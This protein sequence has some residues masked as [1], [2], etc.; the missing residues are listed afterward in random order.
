M[1]SA[2]TVCSDHYYNYFGSQSVGFWRK[3]IILPHMHTLCANVAY[4]EEIAHY[5]VGLLKV[6]YVSAIHLSPTHN[7]YSV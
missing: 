6:R 7:V 2:H 4:S 3:Q 1:H 5:N